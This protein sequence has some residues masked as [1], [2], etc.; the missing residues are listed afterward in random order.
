VVFDQAGDVFEHLRGLAEQDAHFHVDR[1]VFEVGVF[2]HELVVVGRFANDGDGA[3]LAF[4]ESLE[5][6]DAVGHDGHD[7][8]LLGFVAPDLHGRH[9]GVFVVNVA[10]VEASTGGFNELG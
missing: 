2:E 9:G 7:V 4:A 3:A 1:V 10:Q 5:G 8:A 6:V